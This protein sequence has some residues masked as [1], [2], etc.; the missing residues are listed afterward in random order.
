MLVLFNVDSLMFA[1]AAKL[2][3][4]DR[5]DDMA[6][7]DAT[8][9]QRLSKLAATGLM[10]TI[11]DFESVAPTN[12][13]APKCKRNDGQEQANNRARRGPKQLSDF[14]PMHG[15]HEN[16]A[17]AMLLFSHPSTPLPYS[18]PPQRS[19]VPLHSES[20]QSRHHGR[21]VHQTDEHFHAC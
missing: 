6:K 14:K 10:L 12:R 3:I 8:K 11:G 9:R 15:V 16:D 1:Y 7:D 21:Q 18:P 5:Q 4:G 17:L 13:L 19:F 20:D 2:F